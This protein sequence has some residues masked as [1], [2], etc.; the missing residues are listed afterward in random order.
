MGSICKCPRSLEAVGH[1]PKPRIP[2]RPRQMESAFPRLPPPTNAGR[3]AMARP[4]IGPSGGEELARA[5]FPAAATSMGRCLRV[6]SETATSAR[7]LSGIETIPGLFS[8]NG[9]SAAA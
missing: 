3:A 7:K 5:Y 9:A 4:A 6:H 2:A 1:H 8:P